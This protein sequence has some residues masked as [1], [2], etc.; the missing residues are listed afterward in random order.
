MIAA[1]TSMA[2]FAQCPACQREYDD[3][4]HRRFHAQPN[5]CPQC[6]PGL[7]AESGQGEPLAGDPLV[8]ALAAIRRGEILAVRGV[9]GFH[10]VCDARNAEAVARL[11]TR[12]RRRPSPWR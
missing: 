3:P 10:L 8:L 7:W 1:N 6:G 5:A 12:K 9:G 11:R 4:A 2:V